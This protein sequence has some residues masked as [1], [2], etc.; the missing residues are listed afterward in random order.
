[1]SDWDERDFRPE[2]NEDE[3]Y[4]DVIHE[5]DVYE[6]DFYEALPPSASGSS[7]F[8]AWAIWA[9]VVLIVVT[10]GIWLAQ[11]MRPPETPMPDRARVEEKV[12]EPEPPEDEMAA[13]EASS[14]PLPALAESDDF[15]R[16]LLGALTSH[17][18]VTAFFV[19]EGLIRKAVAV[20]V[21][22][23]EGEDPTRHFRHLAPEEPF[24][25]VRRREALYVDP[26]S[27]RRYDSVAAGIASVDAARVAELY[28][29]LEPLLVEAYRELG[30]L[31]KPF[32]QT[33]NQAIGAL[34]S[35]P[36]VE[37]RIE[38][39]AVSVNYAFSDPTLERLQPAQKLL[40]RTG[41]QNLHVIQSKLREIA[42]ALVPVH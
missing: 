5:D 24:E 9:A 32:D 3:V 28:G 41:P 10:G 26:L 31:E 6:D 14:P 8:F 39:H 36:V 17:P 35:T 11:R 19:D 37:D 13:S 30:Y 29:R 2:D 12:A 18:S 7:P 1:M 40:L 33:L 15:V 38:V 21:N 25:V 27:Y 22:V 16:D 23:A 20:I 42:E 34:L 4:E